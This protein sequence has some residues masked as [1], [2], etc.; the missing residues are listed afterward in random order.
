MRP[1]DATASMSRFAL[2]MRQRPSTTFVLACYL[3]A[4]AALCAGA[5]AAASFYP[6]GFYWLS[7][8]ASRLAWR[9]ANPLGAIY[10]SAG[11]TLTMA[12]LI[13]V[14][15]FILAGSTPAGP[16]LRFSRIALHI[17]M[18]GG[19]VFGLERMLIT[20]LNDHVP[21]AHE[22]L[23]LVSSLAWFFGL[24]ALSMHRLK[25][26][27]SGPWP[28]ILTLAPLLI[29]GLGQGILYLDEIRELGWIDR[30]P[31]GVPAPFWLR[32]AFWQWV[33]MASLLAVVS[34]LMVQTMIQRGC[35][36]P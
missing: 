14:I 25:H 15:R 5:L 7:M 24:I 9:N 17:G 10:F 3:M 35:G 16:L 6:R 19:I 21:R 1:G 34:L 29:V 11:F 30:G 31:P 23:V 32:F 36:R 2:R 12:F 33:A 4:V 26:R 20:D 8:S 28:A 27:T 22:L 18:A 13:P